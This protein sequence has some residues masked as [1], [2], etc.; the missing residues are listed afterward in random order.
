[1]TTDLRSRTRSDWEAQARSLRLDGR[2]II[3]GQRRT[4]SSGRTF[5]AVSPVDGRILAAVAR[6]DSTDVDAAVAAARAA[7][8]QG[9]WRTLDPQQRKRVLLR[10][11]ELI[12]DD[13]EQP[14]PARDARCRQ[15]DPRTH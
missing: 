13:L 8:E 5:D 7:F 4:A 15:A 12:R 6:C 10:F 14:R 3:N 1:M 11:A 9:V 2:A